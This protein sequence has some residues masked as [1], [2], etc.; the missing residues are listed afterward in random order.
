[1][2]VCADEQ[3][4]RDA[5]MRV[6]INIVRWLA[7]AS[8]FFSL[9]PPSHSFLLSSLPRFAGKSRWVVAVGLCTRC[10]VAGMSASVRASVT[11]RERNPELQA[12]PAP[13]GSEAREPGRAKRGKVDDVGAAKR[14]SSREP[15]VASVLAERI[16]ARLQSSADPAAKKWIENY[17]KEGV[18]RGNKAPACREALLYSL[19]T[20][21]PLITEPEK[22]T[23]PAARKG[24][25]QISLACL[26]D[27]GCGLVQSIYIDDKFTGILLLSEFVIVDKRAN[28]DPEAAAVLATGT[29]FSRIA[30]LCDGA[31]VSDWPTANGCCL[32]HAFD[33]TASYSDAF[34]ARISA[35]FDCG[36]ISTW[37]SS[38][39]IA[40]MHGCDAN[41]FKR[42]APSRRGCPIAIRIAIRI[43]S[44]R[45]CVRRMRVSAHVPVCV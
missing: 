35:L 33:S 22:G 12:Q 28:T 37:D 9:S 1:M 7:A 13:S 24:A 34:F 43:A 8:L 19:S 3:T 40:S 25:A 4:D 2:A 23:M 18:S 36:A 30:R 10:S 20:F 32:L 14:I 5:V 16:Q 39:G 45:L 29:F 41:D 42:I 21:A 6:N 44:F 17:I 27:A 26:A 15:A 31:F 38:D 11:K